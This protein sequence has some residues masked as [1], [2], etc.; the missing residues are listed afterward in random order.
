MSAATPVGALAGTTE[1]GASS[2]KQKSKPKPGPSILKSGCRVHNFEAKQRKVQ[3]KG[4]VEEKSY[5]VP[6]ESGMEPYTRGQKPDERRQPAGPKGH[7]ETM[8][9]AAM[10]LRNAKEWAM[11]TDDPHH[12]DFGWPILWAGD[13]VYV[14][15]QHDQYNLDEE[16][17]EVQHLKTCTG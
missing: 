16:E 1:S 17:H 8:L 5:A 15:D 9:D 2:V 10:A 4:N 13:V 7:L 11:K 3:F 14:C 12:T 6:S